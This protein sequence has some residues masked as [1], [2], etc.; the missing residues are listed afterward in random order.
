M[1]RG[2]EISFK[3]N[4]AVD[5]SVLNRQKRANFSFI[6]IDQFAWMFEASCLSSVTDIATRRRGSTVATPFVL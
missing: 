6:I 4:S 3:N 5:F 1:R 2:Y